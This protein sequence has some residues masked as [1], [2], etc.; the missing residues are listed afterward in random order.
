M[1]NNSNKFYGEINALQTLVVPAF[2]GVLTS[3]YITEDGTLVFIVY[4]QSTIELATYLKLS[5]LFKFNNPIDC[6]V[7]DKIDDKFRFTVVYNIQSFNGNSRAQ[8]VTK[9]NDLLPLISLQG[10]YPAFN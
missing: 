5:S 6:H 1:Q 8:V 4:R 10:I 7:T 2:T 3:G 9:T